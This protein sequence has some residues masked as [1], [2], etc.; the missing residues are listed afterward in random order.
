MFKYFFSH[1]LSKKN[2]VRNI[3]F[4]IKCN[5]NIGFNI[6]KLLNK[7]WYFI[8]YWLYVCS[9]IEKIEKQ[10]IFTLLINLFLHD[11]KIDSRT[12]MISI[13]CFIKTIFYKI[14]CFAKMSFF[15]RKKQMWE[16]RLFNERYIIFYTIEKVIWFLL[17]FSIF[18]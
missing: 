16:A 2:W 3:Y 1:R 8:S 17:I 6:F 11:N 18:L 4:N 10:L 13:V 9:N 15:N 7:A 12:T 5:L 14:N